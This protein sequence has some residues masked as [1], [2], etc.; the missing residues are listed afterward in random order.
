L[1]RPLPIGDTWRALSGFIDVSDAMRDAAID[2]LDGEA[3]PFAVATFIG[4]CLGPPVVTNTDGELLQFHELTYRITDAS[5]ARRALLEDDR[6]RDHGDGSLVASRS[7][8]G[9]TSLLTIEV[10]DDELVVHANSHRRSTMAQD[11]IAVVLP[12][13]ELVWSETLDPEELHAER[14]NAT[15]EVTSRSVDPD[16]PEMQ[17]A[18]DDYMQHYERTWVDEPVPA[19]HGLTPREAMLDPV[20]REELDRL[21]ATMEDRFDGGTMNPDRVRGL[22]GL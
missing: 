19:L 20:E 22:L 12:D 14:A 3:D 15:G 17:A 4:R 6:V 21:L 13:A 8:V 7:G 9:S 5:E 1:G 11:W 16:D 18:L 10:S 2:L